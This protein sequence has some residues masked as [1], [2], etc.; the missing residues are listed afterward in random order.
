[1]QRRLALRWVLVIIGLVLGAA[2]FANGSVLIGAL[3]AFMALLRGFMLLS[4]HRT[5]ARRSGATGSATP[6][7]A[8]RALVP[9]AFRAAATGLGVTL[10]TV[11]RDFAGGKS[12]AQMAADARVPVDDVVRIMVSGLSDAID[13]EVVAGTMSSRE[14][15]VARSRLPQWTN[16]LVTMHRADLERLERRTAFAAH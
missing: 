8:L 12:I 5:R 2:V 11:R 10:T 4:F 1:M 3:I 7:P 6:R 9:D 13:R 14:G 15:A 16:R